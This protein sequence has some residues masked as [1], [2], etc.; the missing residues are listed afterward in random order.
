VGVNKFQDTNDV[1][2]K[3]NLIDPKSE[4]R[5]IHRLTEFKNSRDKMKVKSALNRLE[6]AAHN[7]HIN[8]MPLIIDA[9]KNRVTLGEI[10]NAFTEVFGLYKP[11]TS[12]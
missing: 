4:R 9:V 11:D 1:E 6:N 10:S 2:P 3:L 5:Q 7:E 8:L 12:F